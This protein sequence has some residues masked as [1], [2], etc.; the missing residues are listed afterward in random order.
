[1]HQDTLIERQLTPSVPV[2]YRL[3]QLAWRFARRQPVGFVSALVIL[4][5]VIVAIFAPLIAPYDPYE[6]T[7]GARLSSPSLDHFFGTDDRGRD[8]FSRVVIGARVSLQVGFLAVGIGIIGG[9]VV[10]LI[11]GYWGGTF[12]LLIQRLM[13]AVLSFPGLVLAMV[14]AA[15]LKP[16]I[17]TA[18]VAIGIVILPSANRVVRGATMSLKENQ[19]VEAARVLGASDRRIML[20]HILPNVLAPIVVMVSIVM[21]F[22]IIVEASLSFLG[23]G[24]QPP[25]PSWGQQLNYGRTYMEDAPWLVLAPGAVIT[26]VVLTFNLL[27]DALRDYFDPSLRGR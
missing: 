9:S 6:M 26:L 22:A 27:G 25:T 2:M 1:M 21:G 8:I 20:F 17:V 4:V 10:G 12:D 7:P 11:T 23:L 16:G 24:V 5:L 18:M 3:S 19:Y 13:D 15:V 14:L